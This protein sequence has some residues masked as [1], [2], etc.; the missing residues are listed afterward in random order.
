MRLAEIKLVS[1]TANQLVKCPSCC[2]TLAFCIP[3]A[4]F[5]IANFLTVFIKRFVTC[6]LRPSSCSTLLE[7]NAPVDTGRKLNVHKTFRR[8]PGRLLNVLCTFNLL[9]V[10]TG[11]NMYVTAVMANFVTI[12]PLCKNWQKLYFEF[13]TFWSFKTVVLSVKVIPYASRNHDQILTPSDI[14]ASRYS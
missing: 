11:D 14:F 13:S 4:Q 5:T 10:S 8:H 2:M 7:T 3:T 9:P 6:T 12:V 1:H